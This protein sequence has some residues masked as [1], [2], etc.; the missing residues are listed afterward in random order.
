M[1]KIYYLQTYPVKIGDVI[2]YNGF[3]TTIT[4]EL[5]ELNPDLFTAKDTIQELLDKAKRDYPA[6]TVFRSFFGEIWTVKNKPRYSL[7]A[8]SS[9]LVDNAYV[10]RD[11][12]WAE[13]LPLKFITEDGVSIYGDMRTYLVHPND[14]GDITSYH[15]L[16]S[17]DSKVKCY[18][19]FYHKKNALAYIEKRKEKTLEDYENMLLTTNIDSINAREVCWFYHT[20]K[21]KEPKLYYTK[22]L[23]LIADNLNDE[24]YIHERGQISFHIN[25][26]GRVNLH[27]GYDEGC[28]Y[29]KSKELVEKARD[30]MGSKLEY[31]FN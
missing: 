26:E 12:R 29:F 28:V 16:W 31:L 8:Y 21:G 14:N 30:I 6:G 19:Y 24:R 23:Q 13:V 25:K 9:I 27:M 10:Y 22:I 5:V 4:E 3:K 18:K 20:L 7:G 15:G 11:G 17:G 1:K 2:E